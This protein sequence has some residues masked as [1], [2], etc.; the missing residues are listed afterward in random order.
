MVRALLQR[1]SIEGGKGQLGRRP[2]DQ[3]RLDLAQMR[4]KIVQKGSPFQ[5]GGEP[6][7]WARGAVRD[8]QVEPSGGGCMGVV[9]GLEES[10]SGLVEL[11]CG[12]I[13]TQGVGA[14]VEVLEGQARGEV[15][16]GAGQ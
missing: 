4:T 8:P 7:R 1:A 13:I 16:P 15:A 11:A 5:S 2:H 12:L 9:D 10:F 14:L 6:E 3:M